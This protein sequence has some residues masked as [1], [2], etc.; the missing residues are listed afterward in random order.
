M[1]TKKQQ[2]KENARKT[3]GRNQQILGSFRVGWS[4]WKVAAE[5]SISYF[6]AKEIFKCR[7]TVNDGGTKF[8]I[9]QTKEDH[10]AGKSLLNT[11]CNK[12]K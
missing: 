11:R 8:G 5:Y 10:N 7:K 4:A 1:K 12:D 9:W 6:W 2:T 3:F